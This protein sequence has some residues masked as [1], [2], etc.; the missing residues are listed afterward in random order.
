MGALGRTAKEEGRSV[1]DAEKLGMIQSQDWTDEVKIAAVGT[2]LGTDL[3]TESGNPT[4]Y[5]KLLEAVDAGGSV[6][7]W[8]AAKALAPEEGANSVSEAQRWRAILEAADNPVDQKAGLLSVMGD[9][10]RM[11]YE[12]ADAYGIEPEAWVQLKEALP[13]FDVNEN[14]SYSGA[15][16]EAAIDALCGDGS[17]VAPWDKEPLRLSREEKAV[18]WQLYTGSTSGKNN[19]YSSRVGNETGKRL[20]KAKEEAEKEEG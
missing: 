17:L 16:I 1:K 14:G 11:K 5:A 20:E 4:Q 2:I 18:L 9:S 12:I 7:T 13:Q 6:D 8:L 3:K 10:A 15:E 19:P